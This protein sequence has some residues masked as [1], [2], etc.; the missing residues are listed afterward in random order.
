MLR[1]VML[2]LM[3]RTGICRGIKAGIRPASG[4]R[5]KLSFRPFFEAGFLSGRRDEMHQECCRSWWRWIWIVLN[6]LIDYLFL[7]DDDRAASRTRAAIG[8]GV[9]LAVALLA[10]AVM[11]A[12]R[13]LE[14]S[15]P[16]NYAGMT[17]QEFLE[18]LQA[19]MPLP[20]VRFGRMKQGSHVRYAVSLD[21]YR[22]PGA[23]SAELTVS[24]ELKADATHAELSKAVDAAAAY[25]ARQ[26][27]D[28]ST[29]RLP[30]TMV[31]PSK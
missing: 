21:A 28:A 9:V 13:S 6:D 7:E 1:E 10:G 17:H 22:V 26:I 27:S 4:M 14:Y 15:P 20:I 8:L 19:K 24:F 30:G 11:A 25:A 16:A 3:L 23:S 29:P 5:E 2:R 31:I 18:L 12:P